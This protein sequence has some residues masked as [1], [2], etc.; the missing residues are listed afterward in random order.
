M[1]HPDCQRGP[2]AKYLHA[3]R[4]KNRSE[5]NSSS[6]D[7]DI[8]RVGS[9]APALSSVTLADVWSA[10]AEASPGTTFTRF[11]PQVRCRNKASLW[12]LAIL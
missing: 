12:L 9:G 8:R 5:L 2:R 3:A 10:V 4:G 6:N 1:L 7:G 11:A